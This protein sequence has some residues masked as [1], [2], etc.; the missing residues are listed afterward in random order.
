LFTKQAAMTI[1][2]VFVHFGVALCKNGESAVFHT[3]QWR[4]WLG[5]V[6]S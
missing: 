2:C 4:H 1:F 5:E 6:D 3:V